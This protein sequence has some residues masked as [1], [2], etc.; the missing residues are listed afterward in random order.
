[1]PVLKATVEVNIWTSVMKLAW[2]MEN[3]NA[4]TNKKMKELSC[5][6]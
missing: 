6:P 4:P 3:K 1:M 5:K 2:A